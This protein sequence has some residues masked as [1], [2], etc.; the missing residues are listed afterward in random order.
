MGEGIGSEGGGGRRG[1]RRRDLD[2]LRVHGNA[3]LLWCLGAPE[4]CALLWDGHRHD[5][6]GK[7]QH[8]AD[9]R[10]VQLQALRSRQLLAVKRLRRRRLD[11]TESG[12]VRRRGDEGK[13][14]GDG[15]RGEG[16]RGEERERRGT[17]PSIASKTTTLPSLMPSQT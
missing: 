2:K 12:R 13:E 11:R 8:A 1:K 3:H 7:M 9:L 14:R 16:R 6:A 5:T 15:K 17:M 4:V 10:A